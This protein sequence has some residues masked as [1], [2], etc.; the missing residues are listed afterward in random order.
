MIGVLGAA[1]SYILPLIGRQ[2][3]VAL[4]IAAAVAVPTWWVKHKLA[5]RDRAV[6]AAAVAQLEAEVA[7]ERADAKARELAAV[8]A[9]AS[10][11]VE[12]HARLARELERIREREA[13]EDKKPA[14]RAT[15][16]R[17]KRV[18]A[19]SKKRTDAQPGGLP[20]DV[21]NAL[22]RRMRP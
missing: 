6:A 20:S 12:E 13:A 11:Y 16:A 4:L 22:D 21:R 8:Q 10:A 18:T 5:E 19:P 9:K 2:L 1:A 15:A 17:A 3:L 7:T 14:A